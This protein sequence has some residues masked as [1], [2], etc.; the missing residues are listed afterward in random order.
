VLERIG[1][2]GTTSFRVGLDLATPPP[3]VDR[4][5]DVLAGTVVGLRRVEAAAAEALTRLSRPDR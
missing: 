2:P 3:E 5:V 4:F 1:V